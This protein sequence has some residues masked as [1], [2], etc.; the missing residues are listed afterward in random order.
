MTCGFFGV[1]EMKNAAVAVERYGRTEVGG[2]ARVLERQH[3]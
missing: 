3:R 2:A 1:D